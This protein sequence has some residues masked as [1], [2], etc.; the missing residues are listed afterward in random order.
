MAA[1]MLER[2]MQKEIP[3]EVVMPMTIAEL[4]RACDE[5]KVRD[6]SRHA[7]ETPELHLKATLYPMGFPTVFQTNS[8]EV[9]ALMEEEW[10]VFA[11][12][13]D[14]KPIE[15]DVHV[16]EGGDSV[17]CP[18]MPQY[19]IMQPI[20]TAIADAGNYSIADFAHARTVVSIERATLRYGSYLK[21]FFL[22]A[23]PMAH[24]STRFGTPVHGASVSLDGRGVILCG[25]S[26]AGKSSLAFACAR[27][28]WTYVTDDATYILNDPSGGETNRQEMA[29]IEVMGN[30]H[31]VR[32]RPSAAELFP[33]LT[34]L[35]IT[36]RAAGKPSIELP[37]APMQKIRCEQTMQ[38]E[39]L[40]FLNRREPGAPE[41]RHYRRDVARE[42]L[43]QVQ[44]GPPESR[45]EQY[46]AIERL[47]KV[48]VFE[49]RYTDLNWAV[50]RLEQ[51]VRE[52]R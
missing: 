38:A 31:Q 25:D 47:L 10:A 22:G 16:C 11:Q 41:L 48:D 52:G 18:P 4:E 46:A 9:I 14:T 19:R 12:R 36:P 43:R 39:F 24:I 51:L 7:L 5:G 30:C 26:G 45:V 44:Y 2:L 13:F 27:A 21:Y 28:G 32:F 3:R 34:G 33:E 17:E 23:A 37:T 6:F 35:D 29:G 49:L 8:A 42:F 15:V 1:K 40:V 20:F 50:A